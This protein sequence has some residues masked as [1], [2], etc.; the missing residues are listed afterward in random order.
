M[1]IEQ[2]GTSATETGTTVHDAATQ[3][4][5]LMTEEGDFDG[6]H[7]EREAEA[8]EGEADEG[9]EGEGEHEG[10]TDEHAEAESES[11]EEE[12]EQQHDEIPDDAKVKVG[13]QEITVHELKRGFLREADYTRKTQ[14]LSEE[15][16]TFEATRDQEL[17]AVRGER[18]KLIHSLE[19][20][21][22]LLNELRPKEPDWDVV[23]RDHPEQYP[24][25]REQWRS[26]LEVQQG[27]EGRKR[28][29]VEQHQKHMQGEFQ[30]YVNAEITKLKD[31]IP[32]WQD[33]KIANADKELMYTAAEKLGY[34]RDEVKSV[35]D[36]RALVVLRK[37]AK[38]DELMAKQKTLR[39][40][41]SKTAP[42]VAAPGNGGA[43]RT[44]KQQEQQRAK[45][46]LAQTGRPRD[47][48]A[49]IYSL[50]DD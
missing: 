26:Y 14:A 4:A 39:P 38:Y 50:L 1:A 6:T 33:S 32:E 20:A 46:R 21:N 22:H 19:Q 30:K 25:L 27:I 5:S 10:E 24:I 7:E 3:F 40:S 9:R 44:G 13:D 28:A 41:P 29:E 45:N 37:A 2:N 47:A 42:K 36:H 31:A 35:T 18:E 12:G 16:R 48:A 11:E 8:N 17:G 15:K 34:T 43:N 49:A 23:L